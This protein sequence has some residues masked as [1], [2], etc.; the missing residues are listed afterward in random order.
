MAQLLDVSARRWSTGVL[1]AAGI[2][3]ERMPPLIDAG[4]VAGGLASDVAAS[5]GLTAG[6]PVHVGGGDTHVSAL[7]AEPS[8]TA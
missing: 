8:R 6:T 5:V 2:D 1:D 7:G 4:A 3:P